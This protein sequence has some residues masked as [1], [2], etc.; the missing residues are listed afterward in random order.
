MHA[1]LNWLWQGCVVALALFAMLGLLERA[2][3]N[4]R[5]L[6]CWAAQLLVLALPLIAWLESGMEQSVRLP[7]VPLEPVVSVPDAWWASGVVMAAAWFVWAAV[8]A[9]RSGRAI[10]ALRRMRALSRPFPGQVES[11]LTHW[12]N[13]RD[14]GRRPRLVVSDAVTAA[15]V[16]GAGAPV[17]AVAPSLVSTLDPD[18]LDRVLIHEWAHVQRRDDLVSVLQIAVRVVAGWHPA[19]WWIDRRLQAEREIACDET[20]VAIVGT[21]KSYAAC[22]LK[23]AGLRGAARPPL[24]APAIVAASGLGVRVARI[25][26]PAAFLTPQRSCVFAAAIAAALA[27]VSVAVAQT[28]LVEPAAFVFPYESIRLAGVRFESLTSG[29]LPAVLS[30]QEVALAPTRTTASNSGDR[31]STGPGAIPMSFA[32]QD[33]ASPVPP[34]AARP[35]EPSEPPPPVETQADR[36]AAP[37]PSPRPAAVT[38]QAAGVTGERERSPWVQAADGGTAIGKKSKEAG[39]ATAGFFSH[40]GRR[41]AGAF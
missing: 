17:I 23:L 36:V 5:Y 11:V 2:R 13:V 28:K 26:S 37:E 12:R 30:R 8:A 27:A 3:A 39:L 22:L 25:V 7:R 32:A 40:F 29:R 9:V 35:A 14:R 19:V 16:L 6:V 15:A 41:V 18:E 1:V 10:A 34:T 33:V 21:P 24:A 4:V 31:P 20:T 38:P